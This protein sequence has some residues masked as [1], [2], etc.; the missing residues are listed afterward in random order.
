MK[1]SI[2]IPAYNEEKRI[3]PTLRSLLDYL[4]R[5]RMVFEII[6]VDDGSTDGT[7]SVVR[8]MA[9]EETRLQL[10]QNGRNRGKGYSVR[11]GM[12]AA[13]GDFMLFYDADA[14]TPAQEIS[15]FFVR[16]EEPRWD[17]AIG[18]RRSSGA[19]ILKRQSPMREING[20]LFSLVTRTLF[21]EIRGI[22]DTQCGF[23]AFRRDVGRAIFS[24]SQINGFSFDV[25]ILV[26]AKRM[27]YRVEEFGVDWVDDRDS[28]VSVSGNINAVLF[29]LGRIWFAPKAK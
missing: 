11:S 24:V 18:S 6:V 5:E 23:K 14:S 7:A 12:L 22:V 20:R 9:K 16:G 28:R 1:L 4:Y 29:E 3:G 8:T 10:L 27:G 13:T 17:V 21:P 15:K 25:E 2:I 19:R 26:Y